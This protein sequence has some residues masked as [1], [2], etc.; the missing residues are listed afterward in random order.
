MSRGTDT[1]ERLVTVARRLFAGKG[2]D[3]ATMGQI[4]RAAG[5]SEGAIY[6]HF[7]DKQELFIACVGPVVEEAFAR[8]LAEVKDAAD[9]R[10][11]IRATIEVRL[12]LIEQNRES[13]DILFTEAPHHAELKELLYELVMKQMANVGPVL[14]RIQEEGHL[15]RRPNLLILGLGMTVGI[16]AILSFRSEH[17]G[18]KDVFGVPLTRQNV[19]DDLVEFVLYGMAGEPAGG[20]A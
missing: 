14:A 7:K 4:A 12:E 19:L 11:V 2:Y 6:R 13:F 3:G 1:R 5:V 9:L 10:R 8:S 16:W 18:M 20:K 17:Q 15:A